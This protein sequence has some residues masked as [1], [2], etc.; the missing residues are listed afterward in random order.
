MKKFTL[1][2][3]PVSK[4]EDSVKV[5]PSSSMYPP[6]FY[7]SDKQM[8]E[9]ENWEVGEKYTMVIEVEQKSMSEG[10]DKSISAN[11]DI[12][13]YKHIPKA[14]VEDMSE[15]EF[16]KYSNKIRSNM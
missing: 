9:I 4:G 12:V 1:K 10:D 6:S 14:S 2:K 3:I 16:I 15:E 11:F 8:P 5:N 13:A 7:V